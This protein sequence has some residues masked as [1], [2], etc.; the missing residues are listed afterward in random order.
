MPMEEEFGHYR[1]KALGQTMTTR[2]N[3]NGDREDHAL[4]GR[5]TASANLNLRLRIG[6]PEAV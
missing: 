6:L 2:H 3:E 5:C 1:K 4:G